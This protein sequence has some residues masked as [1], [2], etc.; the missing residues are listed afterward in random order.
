M[1]TYELWQN[2]EK[3][4]E[5]WVNGEEYTEAWAL[6]DGVP[7]QVWGKNVGGHD[8]DIA[9][10]YGG[11]NWYVLSTKNGTYKRMLVTG[12]NTAGYNIHSNWLMFYGYS[13]NTT[14]ADMEGDTTLCQIPSSDVTNVVGALVPRT[15]NQFSKKNSK[16]VR[17]FTTNNFKTFEIDTENSAL[18]NVVDKEISYNGLTAYSDRGKV[19]PN[20]NLMINQYPSIYICSFRGEYYSSNGYVTATDVETGT[21][22]VIGEI[23]PS[24]SRPSEPYT[25][26]AMVLYKYCYSSYNG[27]IFRHF[28]ENNRW[29][30]WYSTTSSFYCY[31]LDD[32]FNVVAS[33]S[34]QT[35]NSVNRFPLYYDDE[36]GLLIANQSSGT[37]ESTTNLQ[38]FKTE[39]TIPE[40]MNLTIRNTGET[41]T[42]TRTDFIDGLNAY[43]MGGLYTLTHS[44]IEDFPKERWFGLG[45]TFDNVFGE[46]N[47]NCYAFEEVQNTY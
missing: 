42:I 10:L 4:D 15:I 23:P 16:V 37:I 3:Y 39:A 34:C 6:V 7:T 28:K 22:K 43:Y 5:I 20:Q 32:N 45:F 25:S 11:Y 12:E 44:D 2:G 33:G 18:T 17:P 8:W 29:L 47:E 21:T 14:I 35:I 1:A 46:V 38:T 19:I 26:G 36:K 41:R 27:V 24:S 40:S 13:S 9:Y 31:L 30:V